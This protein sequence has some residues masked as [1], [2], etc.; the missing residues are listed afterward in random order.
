MLLPDGTVG[1][2]HWVDRAVV[3][4]DGRVTELQ[5]IGRDITDRKRA[6]DAYRR[7]AHASRLAVVG[8]LT[9]SL[10]H[11]IN[12][13]L[14]AILNNA[15]AAELLL[16]H[17]SARLDEVR[18]ILTDIRKDDLRAS[19]VIRHARE[20]LRKHEPERQPL[21]LG[22]L[23]AGVLQLLGRDA[24][25]RQVALEPELAPALPVVYGDRVHLEQALLNLLLNGMDAMADTPVPRRRLAVRTATQRRR[26]GGRG[27]GQ[28]PWHS[29]DDAA[30]ALRVLLHHEEGRDGLGTAARP[31]DRG[32]ARWPD[33]G[34][35]PPRGR[36]D[37]PVHGA[38]RSRHDRTQSR[39]PRRG[40]RRVGADGGRGPCGLLRA[41]T[42]A[43]SA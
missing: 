8:E 19:G 11:E 35:E 41:A 30:A 22:E 10:A 9:A 40:R 1:W 37:V 7:L 14:N 33:L 16:E 28:R 38:E 27:D 39:H 42:T 36:G 5:G 24:E 2:Q 29:G 32:G 31:L 17:G 25:R 23:V 34:R 43:R 21:D 18:Q 3:A 15:D 13:P 12:Q 4:P 26:G 6:E 20:L